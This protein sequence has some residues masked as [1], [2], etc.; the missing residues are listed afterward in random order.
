MTFQDTYLYKLFTS[1]RWRNRVKTPLP[2]NNSR[3]LPPPTVEEQE[4]TQSYQ[5]NMIQS[6][7]VTTVDE[8]H[9]LLFHA[10]R[11]VESLLMEL[12]ARYCL[13][14]GKEYL[15]RTREDVAVCARLVERY[16]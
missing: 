15:W 7:L 14:T 4:H 12:E 5:A 2:I 11:S 3:P 1:I 16:H 10:K 8:F 13:L 9:A 6:L